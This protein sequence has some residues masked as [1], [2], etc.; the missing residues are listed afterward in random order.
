MA[1]KGFTLIEL[2]VVIAI[3]GILAA[4]LL[5]ALA[6][7]R[8]AA[9]RASCAN[10]LKQQGLVLKMFANESRGNVFPSSYVDQRVK[11]ADVPVG[12]NEYTGIWSTVSIGA[13]FPEYISDVNV[14]YCP[15]DNQAGTNPLRLR[16]MHADSRWGNPALSGYGSV[17]NVARSA[18]EYNL[19]NGIA[20]NTA[21]CHGKYM[22]EGNTGYATQGCFVHTGGDDS[23][24]YWGYLIPYQ[25]VATPYNSGLIGKA[26]DSY[27]NMEHQT[28]DGETV[29]ALTNAQV[30]N[31]GRLSSSIT[32]PG[33]Q[34]GT[35]TKSVTLHPLKEGIE[36]FLITDINNPAASASAQSSIAVTYDHAATWGTKNLGNGNPLPL[37]GQ[38][39]EFNHVPG[40]ANVLFMDG[41]VEWGRFPQPN[42][43]PMYMVTAA[44]HRNGHSY[45]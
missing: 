1:K 22:D 6:R 39:R 42:G 19:Q 28:M 29:P 15:S 35:G 5:P 3:I 7:A 26:V 43:S 17:H 41:H 44:S 24:T 4:I 13:V 45:F 25:D 10:N 11:G 2:L 12:T 23:Y 20:N 38:V 8:E 9:R 36:R 34:T 37:A 27:P 18:A 33:V 14:Y 30:K 31:F 16:W 32:V 40:G 21:P